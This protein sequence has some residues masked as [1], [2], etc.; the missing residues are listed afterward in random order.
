M[1][2]HQNNRAGSHSN[3]RPQRGSRNPFVVAASSPDH[4][5]TSSFST[6]PKPITLV[7]N[8][9]EAF[10]LHRLATQAGDERLA[11]LVKRKIDWTKESNSKIK[12]RVSPSK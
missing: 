6:L 7:M 4:G 11:T 8:E 1:T 2:N 10:N 3:R 12:G 9:E 5:G